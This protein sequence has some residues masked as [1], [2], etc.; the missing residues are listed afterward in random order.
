VSYPS[1]FLPGSWFPRSREL[2]LMGM[3][4]VKHLLQ[5]ALRTHSSLSVP[6]S[7]NKHHGHG[8]GALRSSLPLFWS[9]QNF[10]YVSSGPAL[11]YLSALHR[12][13]CSLL[14]MGL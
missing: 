6:R 2:L 7:R 8:T 13:Q 14:P 12:P 10:S 4:S 3:Y 1:E 9:A 5:S 11:S